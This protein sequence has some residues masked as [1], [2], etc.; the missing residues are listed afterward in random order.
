MT[1]PEAKPFAL[2]GSALGLALGAWN[3]ISF[4]LNPL[5]DS[6]SG[7]LILY[8]PMF[9]SWGVAGFVAVRRTGRLTDAVKAGAVFAFSTFV[10]FWIANIA[11]VNVFLDVLREWP[12]WQTVVTRYR[13][14]VREL[15]SVHQLRLSEGRAN[16]AGGP[17][18]HRRGARLPW[19]ASGLARPAL[20]AQPGEP[21]VSG[22]RA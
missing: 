20:E 11:R 6:V 21:L 16:Q 3:F 5:N 10:I 9:V 13:Q 2:A 4:W 1:I 22:Q 7:M 8:V 18:R 15:S 19:R 14:K 17:D 12:S